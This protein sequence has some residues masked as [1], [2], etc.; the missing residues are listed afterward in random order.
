MSIMSGHTR[1]P[2]SCETVEDIVRY[3][4]VRGL[5]ESPRMK[6]TNQVRAFSN[7]LASGLNN[8]IQRKSY[9]G[10][11]AATAICYI[12]KMLGKHFPGDAL[13]R[14][15]ANIAMS[16]TL[17]SLTRCEIPMESIDALFGRRNHQRIEPTVKFLEMQKEF[18]FAWPP[19]DIGPIDLSVYQSV[20]D[21]PELA[22]L[23]K[24]VKASSKVSVHIE[25]TTSDGVAAARESIC[26][27][28]TPESNGAAEA[29]TESNGAAEVPTRPRAAY[30]AAVSDL[31]APRVEPVS[32][33]SAESA[34]EPYSKRARL[35]R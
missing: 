24:A 5:F 4:I 33:G 9:A 19:I 34:F 6:G 12:E 2:S 3:G 13:I 18:G 25:S 27:E 17:M 20:R 16:V 35:H 1:L 22:A 21:G 15:N 29:T 30:A 31:R 7:L 14:F 32:I 23:S 28:A 8:N 10:I 11:K 26:A